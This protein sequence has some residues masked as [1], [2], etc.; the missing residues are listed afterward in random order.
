MKKVLLV[1]VLGLGLV[2]GGCVESELDKL[3]S[4]QSSLENQIK[5]LDVESE[6]YHQPCMDLA[7][8]YEKVQNQG[9]S[10]AD[11]LKKKGRDVCLKAF[12]AENKALE[13]R[14]EVMNL[15]LAIIAEDLS[16]KEKSK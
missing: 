2:L 14:K 16:N 13:L 3:K 10:D 15:Q 11:E 5:K 7:A 4:D 8:E 12:N 6:K 1:G 9:S